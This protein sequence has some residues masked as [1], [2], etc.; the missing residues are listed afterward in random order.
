VHWSAAVHVPPVIRFAHVPLLQYASG[1]HP[2]SFVHV[3]VQPVPA[4]KKG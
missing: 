4:H 3:L 2:L 1:A